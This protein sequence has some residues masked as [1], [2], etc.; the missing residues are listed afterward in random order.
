MSTKCLD[1]NQNL[2]KYIQQTHNSQNLENLVGN[3]MKGFTLATNLKGGVGVE[4][5]FMHQ[6]SLLI[7]QTRS[8]R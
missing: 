5:T 7:V 3:L 8:L 2:K 1:I 4:N 6:T